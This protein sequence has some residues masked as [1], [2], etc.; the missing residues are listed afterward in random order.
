MTNRTEP[1]KETIAVGAFL[2]AMHDQGLDGAKVREAMLDVLVLSA[3]LQAREGEAVAWSHGCNVLCANIDLWVDRCPHCGKPRPAAPAPQPEQP[4]EPAQPEQSE[5]RLDMVA[6][7]EQGERV[8]LYSLDSDTEGIRARVVHAVLG[9]LAFGARNENKPPAG[10]WLSELWEAA[11]AERARK[12]FYRQDAMDLRDEL[13]SLRELQSAQPVA[14]PMADVAKNATLEAELA[15]LHANGAKAWAGVDPQ[16]LRTGMTPL[17]QPDKQR[18]WN[19]ARHNNPQAI[20][21][22]AME[23]GALV[24]AAHGIGGGA[25]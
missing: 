4:S 23:Y 13:N 10:H 20:E 24:E 11:R 19:D 9:A 21:D 5:Q 7:P 25:L 8:D 15:T 6:Q 2:S 16:E 12:K 3:T 17:S 18:L 14:L 1:T 22:A